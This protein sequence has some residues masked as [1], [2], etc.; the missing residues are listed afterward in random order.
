M[1]LSFKKI[2][3]NKR[4]SV[5]ILSLALA[6]AAL[7]TILTIHNIS[8]S[9][10]E[11]KIQSTVESEAQIFY[12]IGNGIND[13]H[14][15]SRKIKKTGEN[16][17]QV[18]HFEL[19][20]T[21]IYGWRFDP[22]SSPGSIFIASPR[23]ITS[24]QKNPIVIPF[25]AFQ[26][27][28]QIKR[29]Y[30]LPNGILIETVP[31]AFDPRI[32]LNH[33]IDL[34]PEFKVIF[35]PVLQRFLLYFSAYSLLFA[36]A[37]CISFWF[38]GLVESLPPTFP[39]LEAF[40]TRLS[41]LKH[42]QYLAYPATKSKIVQWFLNPGIIVAL[43]CLALFFTILGS[44]LWLIKVFGSDLPFSDQW[45]AEA[46]A[47]YKPYF[48]G[49]LGFKE[50]FAPYNGHRIFFTRVLSLGLLLMNGHWD[51]RLQMVVNAI[52]YSC[53]GCILFFLF[54]R[55]TQ[56]RFNVV[57][58][59]MVALIFSLPL[60]WL[61]TL[62][63]FQSQ[64]YFLIGSSIG[65]I[66]L[67]INYSQ[68]S[69]LWSLG[70]ITGI[71]MLFTMGSGVLTVP[72]IMAILFLQMIRSDDWKKWFM[73]KKL[74]IL[75][76]IVL[77]TAGSLLKTPGDPNCQARYLT[78]FMRIWSKCLSWP[79]SL[80][81]FWS[82]INWMPFVTLAVAYWRRTINDGSAERF[83]LGLGVWV[84]LQ[85]AAIAFARVN[86]MMNS[87]YMD[88]YTLGLLVNFMSFILILSS[89]SK[90]LKILWSVLA[91]WLL[92]N[93]TGLWQVKSHNLQVYLPNYKLIDTACITNVSD[94]LK[95][96]SID[97]LKKN[98]PIPFEEPDE[99]VR[100]LRE[101]TIRKI[102]PASVLPPEEASYKVGMLSVLAVKMVNI[103]PCLL[104]WGKKI[105]SVCVF[106]LI[107]KWMI[108]ACYQNSGY[109]EGT[110]SKI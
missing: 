5:I 47:L 79:Q 78:E 27:E 67:L 70:F 74:T 42:L 106:L 13:V 53:I 59:I 110:V 19:P 75:V 15:Q 94:F 66:W 56:Y 36:A 38:A 95:T 44:R 50:L 4:V 90:K 103:G 51:A 25:E 92:V 9:I 11:M 20:S 77:L 57:W 39:L 60:G 88:V 40:S 26:P 108:T 73:E 98:G 83:T 72:A 2:S 63:G 1:D 89:N 30:S 34:T 107:L 14:S 87:R 101:P 49:T 45:R 48:E 24:T 16:N 104:S 12:D 3:F 28:I 31:G 86:Q 33:S 65:T 21:R 91:I 62:W 100:L 97:Y 29:I 96:D 17:F 46:N 80:Y 84:L 32:R 35:L 23:V 52:I 64:F 37:V 99:L 105:L 85:E 81:D 55:G 10:L 6:V 58:S 82:L 41:F 109:A 76:C 61:N 102:L 22:L 71:C 43:Q 18:I 54:A 68:L 69:P 7:S 93:L 8:P